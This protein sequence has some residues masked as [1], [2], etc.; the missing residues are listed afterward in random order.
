MDYN[1]PMD[2]H[3]I[4]KREQQRLW[5]ERSP[6]CPPDFYPPNLTRWED[7]SEHGKYQAY[8]RD[9]N[10]RRIPP[11]YTPIKGTGQRG[12]PAAVLTEAAREARRLKAL[13]VEA[14]I[15][16]QVQKKLIRENTRVVSIKPQPLR[17]YLHPEAVVIQLD[18]LPQDLSEKDLWEL[19]V[20]QWDHVGISPLSV[21][22]AVGSRRAAPIK[23]PHPR[24]D[25][26][27]DKVQVRP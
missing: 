22:F 18:H 9:P 14:R 13:E 25:G 2:W 10:D 26:T 17:A 21:I 15:R 1:Q 16:R 19:L 12:R 6:L 27:S 24:T 7:L 4:P 11:G 23:N 5:Q 3:K 8:R 20:S